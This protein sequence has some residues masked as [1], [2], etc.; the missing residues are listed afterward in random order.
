MAL[1]EFKDKPN[2]TTPVNANNLN[3]NFNDL[4]NRSIYE[5]GNNDNGNYIKFNDGTM[6]CTI[7]KDY[8]F[9]FKSSQKWGVLW[10]SDSCV[11]GDYP[12]Q[13]ASIPTVNVAIINSTGGIIEYIMNGTK[14]SIGRALILRPVESNET[15]TYK[16]AIIAIGKWK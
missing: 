8:D 2:T 10:E 16:L 1:I 3:N 14:S 7:I 4:D 11:L 6:I 15:R 13:F 5:T 12:A 9:I